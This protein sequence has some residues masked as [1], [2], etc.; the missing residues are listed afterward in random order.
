MI[1]NLH[2]RVP[3]IQPDP[4]ITFFNCLGLVKGLFYGHVEVKDS[5][6]SNITFDL[7]NVRTA[8]L[9][10][11]NMRTDSLFGSLPRELGYLF[12]G[13]D[14]SFGAAGISMAGV[15]LDLGIDLYLR[16]AKIIGPDF[17]QGHLNLTRLYDS[18]YSHRYDDQHQSVDKF[19]LTDWGI[20]IADITVTAVPGLAEK[21]PNAVTVP[22][23]Q[24][25]LIT[26]LDPGGEVDDFVFNILA[27]A[28]WPYSGDHSP[29]L[30]TGSSG[31]GIC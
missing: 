3:R 12:L 13:F 29:K 18:V 17:F 25:S 22:G 8:N 5:W 23:G 21:V 15:H 20:P 6:I 16:I 31:G 11:G 1:G 7:T 24:P 14:G 28:A 4:N 27:Y 10:P 26:M 19:T 30:N 9:Q 2:L